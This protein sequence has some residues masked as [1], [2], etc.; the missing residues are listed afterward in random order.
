MR[1][2]INMLQWQMYLCSD[3]HDNYTAL[4]GFIYHELFCPTK[5]KGS[6]YKIFRNQNFELHSKTHRE[7]IVAF[8]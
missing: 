1:Y 5:E 7:L 2:A 6:K 3:S 4:E 8:D